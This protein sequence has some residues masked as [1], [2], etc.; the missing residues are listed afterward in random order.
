[1]SQYMQFPFWISNVCKG[2]HEFWLRRNN[3]SPFSTMERSWIGSTWFA[4]SCIDVFFDDCVSDYQAVS[5]LKKRITIYLPHFFKQKLLDTIFKNLI[6][7]KASFFDSILA[8]FFGYEILIGL[9]ISFPRP[10]FG[11]FFL[12]RREPHPP[13]LANFLATESLSAWSFFH[14]G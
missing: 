1:M 4:K 13:Y 12:P 7:R 10:T 11:S 14:I 2:V 6:F 8:I 5:S 3:L 9:K